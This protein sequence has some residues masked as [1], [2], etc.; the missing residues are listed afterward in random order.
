M[1]IIN[2]MIMT[3]NK[4]IINLKNVPKGTVHLQLLF[5][6]DSYGMEKKNYYASQWGP[7]EGE[8]SL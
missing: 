8:L 1:V 7:T 4:L 5:P 2:L 3:I 6:I